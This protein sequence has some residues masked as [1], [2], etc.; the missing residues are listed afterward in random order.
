MGV[1]DYMLNDSISATLSATAY[2]SSRQIEVL[3]GTLIG[4]GFFRPTKTKGVGIRFEQSDSNIGYLERLQ[5]E[6]AGMTT[7]IVP[8]KRKP[9]SRTGNTYSSHRMQI[10]SSHLFT[11]FHE[12]FVVDGTRVI[13]ESLVEGFTPLSLAFLIM[14]NG[15]V[16]E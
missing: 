6:F 13:P 8:V 12:K 10:S 1:F 15:I 3:N 2:L 5:E 4:S 16:G 14:S 9:D 7:E 11:P